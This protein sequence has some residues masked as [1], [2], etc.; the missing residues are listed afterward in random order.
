M[1]Y[2]YETMPVPNPLTRY[3]HRMPRM[4]H[5]FEVLANHFVEL[6]APWLL[7]LPGISR[8]WRIT[9]GVIQLAFQGILITSGNFSFLNW[10]TML[11]SLYCF[12]DAFVSKLFSPGYTTSASIAAYTHLSIASGGAI[13]IRRLVNLLFLSLIATLSIPVVKNLLSKKQIMNCSFDPLRLVNTYGA[14][15]TV[16]EVREELIIEAADD[17]AGPW[18][19]Y[20]FKVKPGKVNRMPRFVSPYH[21]RLDWLMWI[22][23]LGRDINRNPWMY[24]FLKKLLEN[25]PE[26]TKLLAKDPFDD[27]EGGEGEGGAKY[28][29][30]MKYKY[31]FGSSTKQ[32]GGTYWERENVG[33]FFP[34]QGLCDLD[35][36]EDITSRA[37]R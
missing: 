18:R 35:M 14:F 15:G 22:A 12:D 16:E 31:K 2:F 21:Y 11:P 28:I 4:W 17:Y 34:K 5:R 7:I 37:L 3:F 33:R 6:V 32:E 8:R 9:G 20:E 36:L 19:E 13:F 23:S 24:S 27:C 10:L 25:D 26:V 1:D 29:R 30:V